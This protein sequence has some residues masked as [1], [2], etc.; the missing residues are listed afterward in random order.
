MIA[1][2]PVVLVAEDDPSVRLTLQF[3]L[4]IEGFEVLFAE[5]GEEALAVARSSLPDLILLDQLMP[6]MGGK[7]VLGH[8]RRADETSGIP[9]FVMT[10]MELDSSPEWEGVT[11]VGKP[12]D[13]DYLLDRIRNVLEPL[14]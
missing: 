7:Q 1:R 8:L 9:V 2:P 4:E 11:F 10:G 13:P 14:N 6:L 3:I 5:N 12:F